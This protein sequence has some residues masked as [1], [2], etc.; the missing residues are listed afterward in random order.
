MSTVPE[1]NEIKDENPSAVQPES[2]TAEASQKGS[3]GDNA[4]GKKRSLRAFFSRPPF[5]Y[6][7]VQ[8]YLLSFLTTYVVE[9]LS[10]YKTLPQFIHVVKHP[11]VFFAN[12]LIVS[13]VFIPAILFRKRVF[14]FIMA[15]V[16]WLTVG[17]VDFIV[18]HNRVTPFNA[19]DF[20]MIDDALNVVVHYFTP[21]QI[22]MVIVL[23]LIGLFAIV[24]S[25]IKSP[26]TAKPVS[27]KT[28]IPLCAALIGLHIAL[29]S[30]S[31]HTGILQ[32]TF[33]NLANGYQ[34]YGL[35]YC[36]TFSIVDKGIKKPSGYS[37]GRV[38]EVISS[39]PSSSPTPDT[40]VVKDP[41]NMPNIIVIQL[42]SFFDPKRIDGIRFD[43][44]PIPNFTHLYN[45]YSSGFLTVP[46]ISA[47]TANTE[48]EILTGMNMA[49]FGTGEYP[50]RTILQ[51]STCESLAYNLKSLGY[52]CHAIHN[53]TA[54]FY[55]R[56][57]VFSNLGFDDYDAIETMTGVERNAL[58]W[59]KD[60]IL[61]PEIVTALDSTEGPDFVFAV[62]V[63]GHGKYPDEDILEN[64]I[65]LNRL[66]AAYEDSTFNGLRY[67][68]SQLNEMD[69]FIGTLISYLSERK[70][71]TV[72][73]LYGDHLPGFDF[74][75]EDLKFGTLLQ[76]EYVIWSNF[77]ME[78][79]HKDLNAY[80]LSAYVQERL[81]LH[82]GFV[83]RLHQRHLHDEEPNSAVYLEELQVLS[84]DMLY[85][86]KYC[87]DG[88]NPYEPTVMKFGFSNPTVTDVHAVFDSAG[89][90]YLTVYGTR[91]TPYASVYINGVRYK[92]TIYVTE[93]ELFLP[94]I[95]LN[96]GD[97]ISVGIINDGTLYSQSGELLFQ[98]TDYQ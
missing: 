66:S 9:A 77:P 72:L 92:E 25:A 33:P 52:G 75:E 60:K 48:F 91:F 14:A 97:R 73:V 95:T 68:T 37:K 96:E 86:E 81:N 79:V 38:D 23:I 67:Y 21:F 12:M 62:S 44:D 54:S 63:Q 45:H 15:T 51:S 34:Q 46:S 22:I 43:T 29:I 78:A 8:I 61:Y 6:R 2:N 32:R 24:F 80:Q 4:S 19:N 3:D 64:T 74:E 27:F 5:T 40:P 42:E 17:V 28:T 76:T 1:S 39:L 55:G 58:N 83:T 18:L 82:E 84:Y 11:L 89:S 13:I 98:K 65:T 85:G 94:K 16:I 57:V 71:K 56:D 36:F 50:Y 26:K 20:K 53:N 59:A 49:D 47:G 35:P 88:V 41:D 10:H 90:C 30:A 69:A 93:N 7:L 31:V 70:E 87:W